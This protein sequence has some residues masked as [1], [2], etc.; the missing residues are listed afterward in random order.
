MAQSF[1]L[2]LLT[3][4]Q[5]TLDRPIQHLAPGVL[6][7]QEL[8]RGMSLKKAGPIWLRTRQPFLEECTYHRKRHN[9]TQL[10]AFFGDKT[11]EECANGDLIRQYQVQRRKKAGPDCINKETL[12]LKSILTRAGV[13]NGDDFQALPLDPPMA[14]RALSPEEE[15]AFVKAAHTR[16][17][18]R[19][20]YL[21]GV[22]AAHTLLNPSEIFKMRRKDVD[23]TKGAVEVRKG[24]NKHRV[25]EVP[26]NGQAMAAMEALWKRSEELGCW[27]PDHFLLPYRI[28]RGTFDPER[29]AVNCRTAW[30][31]LTRSIGLRGLR[32]KD[33]RHHGITV[34]DENKTSDRVTKALA[35]HS[36]NS[37]LL[38]RYSHARFEAKRGAV[39]VL[40]REVKITMG[41]KKKMTAAE[42]AAFLAEQK[43]AK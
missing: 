9:L 30:R 35:G 3:K 34:L 16:E 20:A 39:D 33:M 8:H 31:K 38:D 17:E 23:L 7:H 4:A 37:K 26:L 13:W 29:H 5:S 27:R 24:K 18:W 25:R 40:E 11:L 14:G 43:A 1:F 12:V 21:V 42:V 28:K 10:I 22:L 6:R 41:M 2:K 32:V 19:I 15:E 36:P